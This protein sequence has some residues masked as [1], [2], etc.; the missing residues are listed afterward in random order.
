MK[1]GFFIFLTAFLGAGVWLFAQNGI[2]HPP[3]KN[4]SQTGNSGAATS[5]NTRIESPP[6]LNM[7]PEPPKVTSWT[8]AEAFPNLPNL[9]CLVGAAQV[10]NTD[11]LLVFEQYGRVY[12]QKNSPGA[13]E[14][15][16]FLNLS[17]RTFAPGDTGLL[18]IVFHPEFGMPNSTNREFFYVWYS[19]HPNRQEFKDGELFFT[20][21]NRLSRFTWKE[22]E[23]AADPQSEV[24]LI[25]QED[26]HVFHAGGGMA[27]GPDGFLYISIADEGGVDDELGSAQQITEN[28]FSGA[29]RIDVDMRGGEISHPIKRQPTRGRTANYFIPNSNP[30]SG[31]EGALEEFYAIGLRNPHRMTYDAPSGKFWIGDVGQAG[32]EEINW[33]APGANYQWPF[34][35]G[36]LSRSDRPENA[37]GKDTKPVYEYPHE[38]GFCIIGGSVYRGAKYFQDLGGKYIY[39]DLN[40]SLWALPFDNDTVG[41]PELLARIPGPWVISSIL[42]DDA[43]DVLISSIG[44]SLIYKLQPNSENGSHFPTHLSETGIFEDAKTL[45]P[46]PSLVPYAVNSPLWSD[47]AEKMRWM[48]IPY[49]QSLGDAANKIIL[50]ASGQLEFPA[51]SLFVKNFQILTNENDPGSVKRL[52]TRVLAKK[53]DGKVY[54]VTYKWRDD[55]SDADLLTSSLVEEYEVMTSSGV[56]T[57]KWYYPS[58]GDCMTCH[59]PAANYVLGVSLKQLNLDLNQ[60]ETAINQLV[61]L[62]NAGILASE[63]PITENTV[64]ELPV[65]PNPLD[66]GKP[67][68]ARVRSYLDA[69][70][71]HCHRPGGVRAN[72]DARYETIL[73]LQGLIQ[74]RP[75]NPLGLDHA[76][77]IN[78]GNPDE[79]V[80]YKRIGSLSEIKMPPLAK[81]VLD[82]KAMEVV[83]NW[84]KSIPSVSILPLNGAVIDKINLELRASAET[85]S[86]NQ[87]QKIAIYLN[88]G[89]IA[90][91]ETT[92]LDALLSDLPDGQY[93]IF[94][95][96]LDEEGVAIR[97]Q[98]NLITLSRAV[99]VIQIDSPAANQIIANN[100]VT[101]SAVSFEANGNSVSKL[102]FYLDGNLLGSPE[103]QNDR[104]TML[105]RILQPGAHQLIAKVYDEEGR[106]FSSPPISFEA[107]P[108]P[109]VTLGSAGQRVITVPLTNLSA[110]LE[111]IHNDDIWGPYFLKPEGIIDGIPDAFS[112]PT[113]ILVPN[114]LDTP[115]TGLKQALVTPRESGLISVSV[116]LRATDRELPMLFG[117]SDA[118]LSEAIV[119]TN[120]QQFRATF[121]ALTNGSYNDF[122]LF[123]ILEQQ[124]NGSAWE[125]AQPEIYKVPE[126][127][128]PIKVEQAGGEIVTTEVYVNGELVMESPSLDFEFKRPLPYPGLY[129]ILVRSQNNYGLWSL[130]MKVNVYAEANS[131]KLLWKDKQKGVI[132]Y[133]PPGVKLLIES[134]TDLISWHEEFQVRLDSWINEFDVSS[135][136]QPTDAVYLRMRIADPE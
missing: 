108:L 27:F 46:I 64:H 67:L 95:E 73:A 25:E 82:V 36:T 47:G 92:T 132:V 98:T 54:G 42:I 100:N 89:L 71:A 30:W 49:D 24:I 5:S 117:I 63:N 1:G 23:E 33:L 10:P 45:K 20:T 75:E 84:I 9:P 135:Q 119:K 131:I 105:I 19:H 118:F 35:E 52:E 115:T 39:G 12:K 21:T 104:Y 18:N 136:I 48:H 122:R 79:S 15:T 110:R 14:R 111:D 62:Y 94:A 87:I 102:E 130:P 16:L 4:S 2:T 68:S 109:K 99:P 96:I 66:P 61:T 133:G 129:Q 83:S 3:E 86:P 26:R 91:G 77:L 113:A 43:G 121:D 78:P 127:T 74:G 56:E 134:S 103:G 120:W 59:T 57:R 34:R 80:I 50:N 41:E 11:E 22:G 17:D 29:L 65:I 51:G 85:T 81:N 106:S 112:E 90:S 123:E 7:P 31:Q 44:D 125:M 69:N 93:S 8:V 70:C 88:G 37:I 126:W 116:W 107:E 60:G 55:Q 128:L 32:R 58:M 53:T 13:Q 38:T 72:F 76:Q 97:S 114:V 40:G 28:L 124:E 101:F 6:F